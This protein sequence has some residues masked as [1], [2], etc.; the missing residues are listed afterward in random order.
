MKYDV[1]IS[2]S[3]SDKDEVARPLAEA[4]AK[5]GLKV[6]LDEEQ[7]QIGDSIRRG[8]GSA[9]LKSQYAVVILSPAYFESE[10][11]QKELD[12]FFAKEK[13]QNKSILP[14]CHEIDIE[15]VEQNWPLLADKV[16]LNSEKGAEFIA[17]KIQ[18]SIQ[19]V[20]PQGEFKSQRD[21]KRKW[22]PDSNWQWLIALIVGSAV[23][24]Y[25]LIFPGEPAPQSNTTYITNIVS[26]SPEELRIETAA[27]EKELSEPAKIMTNEESEAS[28]YIIIGNSRYLTDAVGALEAYQ[29]A[30]EVD[31]GNMVAWNR[32]GLI[33]QRL[34]RLDEAKEAFLK[35]L[36]V[37]QSDENLKF[38]IIANNNLGSIYSSQQELDKSREYHQA[39]LNLSQDLSFQEGIADQYTNLGITYLA[40]FHTSGNI[41]DLEKAEDY[42]TDSWTINKGLG[43]SFGLA[44][45]YANLGLVYMGQNK[46]SY[47]EKSLKKAAE[48][49]SANH[50][51]DALAT[52]YGN[53]GKIYLERGKMP[54]L[55]QALKYYKDSLEIEKVLG[56]IEGMAIDLGNIGEI[57]KAQGKLGEACQNWK[58]SVDLFKEANSKDINKIQVLI[59]TDCVP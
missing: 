56:R 3:S 34:G 14:I 46:M 27:R 21:K 1:F 30:T 9:L 26:P 43:R 6:W 57:Y 20:M 16:S 42:F 28:G 29:K 59:D 41:K 31:P 23:A 11:G 5:R 55:D 18:Q 36:N 51:I 17:D 12:A 54:D 4:L 2:H 32:Q 48:I 25:P 37:K 58:K 38:K 10:W 7:L 15:D 53:L 44:R 22:W 40:S 47:A 50:W 49:N 45:D 35:V 13:N 19:E 33:Q 52:N 39:A 8:L 24:L